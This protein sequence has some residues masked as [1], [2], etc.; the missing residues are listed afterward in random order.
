MD[1][2]VEEEGEEAKRSNLVLG[3]GEEVKGSAGIPVN[4]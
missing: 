2:I 1:L 4:S 3:K